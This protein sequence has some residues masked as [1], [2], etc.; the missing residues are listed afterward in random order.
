MWT[1]RLLA[2]ALTA[3][4]ACVTVAQP[5]APPPA[6]ALTP[7]WSYGHD[8]RARKAGTTDFDKDTPKIGVEFYQDAAAGSV[9]AVTQEG[10]LAVTHSTAVGPVKKAPWLFAHDLSSRKG[11]EDRF[12]PAT[13]K[14]GV[15][16]FND[17]ASGRVLYLNEKGTVAFAEVPTA[18]ATNKP[19][20]WHH[21]L[22]VKV[23]AAKEQDFA[24]ETKKFGVEVFKDGNTGG[25]IYVSETGSIAAAPA[26]ATAPAPDSVKAPKA[27]YGLT[28]RCR[29]S[30][31][32][33]FGVDTRTFSVEVFR[34]E[35]TGGLLY[36]SETGAIA[37]VPPAEAKSGQGVAWKY[38]MALKARPGGVAEFANAKRFGVELYQDGN[39]GNLVYLAETGSIAVLPRK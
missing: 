25:L 28:M 30:D 37:T 15:E 10:A 34:D 12:T 38:G 27:L 33:D 35:N 22:I 5:P 8:L 23:R 14:F 3:T 4:T 16:A 13:A 7:T 24:K 19:P 1:R 31:E 20:A 18:V 6:P 29:K 39:T 21:A 32:A 26:P 36:I 11:D 2:L 9:V 17:N